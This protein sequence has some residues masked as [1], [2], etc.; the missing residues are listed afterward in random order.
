LPC[1]RLRS[2]DTVAIA[3]D[4]NSQSVLF[5]RNNVLEKNMKLKQNHLKEW[6]IFPCVVISDG[7]EIVIENL[8][9]MPIP[10]QGCYL[11]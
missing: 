9:E 3:L 1:A 11:K 7:T 10:L 4:F 6:E 8:Q 2:G 5:F